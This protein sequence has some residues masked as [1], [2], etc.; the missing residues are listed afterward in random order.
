MRARAAS[1]YALFDTPIGRCGIAWGERGIVAVQLPE[2]SDALTCERML[3]GT[4]AAALE[5]P[6]PPPVLEAIARINALLHGKPDDLR[7]IVLD[8]SGVSAFCRRVY[9]ITRAIAPG[10]TLSYGQVAAALGQPG[11][12]RAVGRALAVNPFAP[13]VPCHRVVT[14]SGKPGGFSALGGVDTKM[15]M[16]QIEHARIGQPEPTRQAGVSRP[17]STGR[18]Q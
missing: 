16:L 14:T 7:S 4:H 8:M 12:A 5:A 1:S 11:A 3:H 17:A 2:A 9:A 10:S 18:R 13:V 6:P 15:H